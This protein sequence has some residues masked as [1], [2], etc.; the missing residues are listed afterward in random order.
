MNGV[1]WRYAQQMNLYEDVQPGARLWAWPVPLW[2]WPPHAHLYHLSCHFVWSSSSCHFICRRPRGWSADVTSWPVTQHVMDSPRSEL[3]PR[4]AL[5]LLRAASSC[6]EKS[7]SLLH[8]IRLRGLDRAR[9]HQR[10]F[11][12]LYVK[13]IY[14][15]C[16][17]A[18]SSHTMCPFL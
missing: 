15:P 2:S 8:V 11:Y 3:W 5:P 18:S 16:S 13:C 14:I 1:S 10:A 4:F 7:L 9:G 12:R 17:R 6:T